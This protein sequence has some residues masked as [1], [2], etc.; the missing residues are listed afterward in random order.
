MT[1]QL[2][3]KLMILPALALAGM[4]FGQTWN[5][6]DATVPASNRSGH[7]DRNWATAASWEESGYP[8]IASDSA[9]SD[10]Y[11]FNQSISRWQLVRLPALDQQPGG[12]LGTLQGGFH[13]S[14]VL[15]ST[16][17][18][19]NRLFMVVNP[20]D[21]VGDW[22]IE[23]ASPGVG[24]ETGFM[25]PATESF[26]PVLQRVNIAGGMQFKVATGGTAELVY[27]FGEGT[28]AV[29]K[30]ITGLP[31]TAGTLA[32]TRSPGPRGGLRVYAGE[33]VL[34]GRAYA[35]GASYVSGTA[36]HLD[37]SNPDTLTTDANGFV[38]AWRDADG[39][40]RFARPVASTAAPKVRAGYVNGRAVVDFGAQR[41]DSTTVYGDPSE[42]GNPSRLELDE[43]VGGIREF[44]VVFADTTPTNC[45]AAFVNVDTYSRA[46]TAGALFGNDHPLLAD[47]TSFAAIETADI[48]LDAQA[49]AHTVSDVDF[50]RGLHVVGVG[51]RG[52]YTGVLSVLG[53]PNASG[54]RSGGTRVAEILAYTRA[55]TPDERRQNV[56]YLRRKWQA[57]NDVAD[58]D[59]GVLSLEGSATVSVADGTTV[60]VG[61][62]RVAD[63]VAKLV[64][65]GGGTLVIDS[66]LTP[67]VPVEV[68]GGSVKF[69]DSGETAE[70]A[71]AAGPLVWL[72]A[73]T[74]SGDS[75][76]EWADARGEDAADISASREADTYPA[77]TIDTT[78]VAG[79]KMVDMGAA[80]SQTGDSTYF[81]VKKD[82]TKLG[83]DVRC[84]FMVYYKNVASAVVP[85]SADNSLRVTSG[86]TSFISD[87]WANAHAVGGAWTLDGQP[88]DPTDCRAAGGNTVGE[89]HVVGFRFSSKLP[90]NMLGA[91]RD[92]VVGSAKNNHGG[93]KFGEVLLY[94]RIL[95]E[96]E[97]KDTEAYL[98]K[99]WKET[100]HP[101]DMANEQPLDLTYAGDADNVID[102]D[103]DRG[104]ASVTL[105]VAKPVVKR[106]SGTVTVPTALASTVPSCAVE[107]GLLIASVEFALK[108][109]LSRAYYHGDA[110]DASSLLTTTV[111]GV[112]R[113]DGWK[114]ASGQ[115]ITAQPH[116][117]P[118]TEDRPILADAT[119]NG[120]SRK[121]VDFGSYA[122]VK[123]SQLPTDGTSYGM[124]ING[125]TAAPL[126][127][128]H[129]VACD[130]DS[131]DGTADSARSPIV[132]NYAQTSLVDNSNPIW[133]GDQKGYLAI[134]RQASAF[135]YGD[136]WL[137]GES[138]IAFE[139]IPAFR[140][141][142][143]VTMVPT[144]TLS[145]AWTLARRS[146]N[147]IGGVKIG[148]VIMF[149]ERNTVAERQALD[150]YLAKKW[151]GTGDGY[152]QAFETLAAESGSALRLSLVEGMTAS[153]GTLSGGG[154]VGVGNVSTAHVTVGDDPAV[155]GT[156]TVDGN[157]TLANG[158]TLCVDLSSAACD[159][160]VVSGWLKLAGTGVVQAELIPGSG[161]LDDEYV[162]AEAVGGIVCDNLNAWTVNSA[163]GV[164][165]KLRIVDGTKL[166]LGFKIRGFSLIFR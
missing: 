8:L 148:E 123:S 68:R 28:F 113:V 126:A 51:H 12:Y 11:T 91:D 140:Q 5:W 9:L 144:N 115:A 73:N 82:G 164:S 53:A 57:A 161:R 127:E 151:F 36:L 78:T 129:Y 104:L 38:T 141:F 111:D 103:S 147:E 157:L 33:V 135:A 99:K 107:G 62:L 40:V 130:S 71:K 131:K 86:N 1:T 150:A 87:T 79:K 165:A 60:E 13:N 72:D 112:V 31:D 114:S 15:T 61:E 108:D 106:G 59:Y 110:M 32:I 139:A 121:V 162:I 14:I 119:I 154:T 30:S 66:Y 46:L 52:N 105:N 88:I 37:A 56:A 64:K 21:Y 97:W 74:L 122:T 77:A 160:L 65:T 19:A 95:S 81:L 58:L 45:G 7:G 153:A 166:V 44:F 117:T 92:A 35:D 69:A 133:R 118:Q 70:P 83:N 29:N 101:A 2:Y 25:L 93:I 23:G 134:K 3:K 49:V 102:V 50:S 34:T 109:V 4:S 16:G 100:R 48:S 47:K 89:V 76:T 124:T 145:V 137:N 152:L 125:N 6:T 27:P 116:D 138:V 163:T 120:L 39:G 43:A 94:D 146:N 41:Y 80:F 132:G 96:R 17:K 84:G 63:G 75:V 42:L 155:A 90:A 136:A 142:Y 98:I 24:V 159:K 143:Q 10:A 18:Q 85:S 26:T 20:N 158:A 128:L 22:M 54:N 156:L 149:S 67:D 55:L